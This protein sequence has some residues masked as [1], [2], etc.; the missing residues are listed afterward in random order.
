MMTATNQERDQEVDA[1]FTI[2]GHALVEGDSLTVATL[3]ETPALLLA[4]AGVQAIARREEV[5]RFFAGGRAQYTDRGVT[6]T[7]ADVEQREWLGE[8]VVLVRVRWPYHDSS[9]REVGNE[10]STYALRR[11]DEGALRIRAVLA[12]N[13]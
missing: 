13:E 8:R 5:E 4:D 2:L 9:G 3:Y 12:H 10:R 11:D 7:R 1:F 6:S